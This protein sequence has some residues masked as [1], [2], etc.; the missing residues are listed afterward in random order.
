[1]IYIHVGAKPPPKCF[2]RIWEKN[3]KIAA[4]QARKGLWV[5]W[6]FLGGAEKM[7]FFGGLVPNTAYRRAFSTGSHLKG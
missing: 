3:F 2:I 6:P 7:Q 1:M 4:K 5:C